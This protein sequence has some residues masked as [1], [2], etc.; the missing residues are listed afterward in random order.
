MPATFYTSDDFDERFDALETAIAKLVSGIVT[1]VTTVEIRVP[2][3]AFVT[4][5][6]VVS[7]TPVPAS[8][9]VPSPGLEAAAAIV[10]SMA[11]GE[12]RAIGTNTQLSVA[13]P[14]EQT[15]WLVQGPFAVMNSWG[16]AAFD[17]KRNILVLS[18]GGH[19]DYGG[20]EVYHFL[21]ETLTW[22][23]ATDPS[24]VEHL[25]QGVY[26]ITDGSEAPLSFHGYDGMQ[27]LPDQ[28]RVFVLPQASMTSGNCYDA[29]AYLYDPVSTSWKRGAKPPVATNETGTDWWVNGRR[30]VVSYYNGY[31]LYDPET[32][33]WTK[34]TTRDDQNTGY[35]GAIDQERNLFVQLRSDGLVYYD[36]TKPGYGREKA[37]LTGDT[38][39]R[40]Y[41]NGGIAW[42]P[43]QK[44]FF[45][46]GGG[47]DV[48]A[49]DQNWNCVR[50]TT[51]GPAVIL[52]YP[53][54]WGKW[55]YVP[56][57]NVFVGCRRGG[58]QVYVFKPPLPGQAAETP[59]PT[60]TPAQVIAGLKDGQT[61]ALPKG[62]FRES[63]VINQSNVT[64]KGY[65][66]VLREAAGEGGKA[67]AIIHGANVRIEGLTV[68][69]AVGDSATGAFYSDAPG[70]T[71]FECKT[72]NCPQN[73][74]TGRGEQITV[75]LDACTFGATRPSGQSQHSLY[76]DQIGALMVTGCTFNGA[77]A[78]GHL[79]KS[80]A[81]RNVI[82]ANNILQGETGCSRAIDLGQG[83]ENII[84]ENHIGVGRN[85]DNPDVISVCRDD[86]LGTP[87]FPEW[88][89]ET[90]I[91]R[92]KFVVD[93]NNPAYVPGSH[94]SQFIMV[95]LGSNHQATLTDNVLVGPG[96]PW[97]AVW[98]ADGI[99]THKPV[100]GT[101]NV[102]YP[103]RAAA[104]MQP[105]PS[106]S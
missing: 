87:L 93:W 74:R 18:G 59:E 49:V 9:S 61:V 73:V 95:T 42:H 19:G 27:Y 97:R 37:P 20:N 81:R 32:D 85:T 51:N 100:I 1:V 65:E 24:P 101:G 11:A 54:V 40:D 58:E 35:A 10:A 21:L 83:G 72:I 17:T 50:Y 6:P 64:I 106:L 13:P 7:V 55:Q 63:I 25:G 5:T 70:T 29:F 14:R 67:T 57:L 60:A 68:K 89:G 3:T 69:D 79:I 38:S 56:D 94:W 96:A 34:G 62:E 92:N 28:D 31:N 2:V 33:A 88:P 48:W 105:Y 43:V 77:E 16:A 103:D 80:R 82:V 41:R 26:R 66:T 99:G 22:V 75:T 15:T 23:R 30:V 71:L 78:G 46:W 84:E 53:G 4:V 45:I 8:V 86:N 47:P 98:A 91:R 36:L 104:G 90:I 12:F 102:E 44:R 39:F 52:G 76:I